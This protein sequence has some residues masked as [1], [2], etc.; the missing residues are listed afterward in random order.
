MYKIA[1]EHLQTINN[2]VLGDVW[3][4]FNLQ[5]RLF[6]EKEANCYCNNL[7]TANKVTIE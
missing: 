7:L 2:S 1:F 6:L 4:V 5:M 3:I